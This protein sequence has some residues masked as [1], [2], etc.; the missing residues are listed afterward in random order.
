MR[1]TARKRKRTRF[2]PVGRWIRKEK[3]REIYERDGFQ[4]LICEKDLK[5]AGPS[6]ITLDHAVPRKLGGSNEA[7]NL[8]TACRPC[9]S[10]RRDKS[11]YELPLRAWQRVMVA[12]GRSAE[13]VPCSCGGLAVRS[14]FLPGSLRKTGICSLHAGATVRLVSYEAE[15]GTRWAVARGSGR[16]RFPLFDL[17]RP[18]PHVLERLPK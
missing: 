9:N 15:G 12:I 6:E 7:S 2:Q 18:H 13:S 17:L 1:S 11:I 5:L 3:R 10:R 4:C 8:F 14:G 16:P